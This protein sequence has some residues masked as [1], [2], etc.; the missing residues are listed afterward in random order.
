MRL[1][2]GG[3]GGEAESTLEGWSREERGQKSRE[4][5]ARHGP[6]RTTFF[7]LNWPAPPRPGG[8]RQSPDPRADDRE[9]RRKEVHGPPPMLGNAGGKTKYRRVMLNSPNV[10]R[11]VHTRELVCSGCSAWESAPEDHP[12]ESWQSACIA[13][14]GCHSVTTTERV[15]TECRRWSSVGSSGEAQSNTE[16]YGVIRVGPLW[17]RPIPVSS[18]TF[19]Q[20]D[21]ATS[22]RAKATTAHAGSC[23]SVRVNAGM[24]GRQSALA[25][26]R[27]TTLDRP[28]RPP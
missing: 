15:R 9:E 1:R 3:G 21:L 6:P 17:H 4:S 23:R 7:A 12:R 24:A 26:L 25:F 11:R 14:H 20:D 5:R 8:F 28:Y 19:P 13:L 2:V 16:G 18:R 22:N 10:C 27:L